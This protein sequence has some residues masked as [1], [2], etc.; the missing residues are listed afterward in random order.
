MYI[1]PKANTGFR[2]I[3]GY[4]GKVGRLY[5]IFPLLL[6]FWGYFEHFRIIYIEVELPSSSQFARNSGIASKQD[7]LR[8]QMF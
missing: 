1:L 2:G 5:G 4:L 3:L 6:Q 7:K 8:P